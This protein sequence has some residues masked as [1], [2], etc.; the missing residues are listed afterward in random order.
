MVLR[1]S[2]RAGAIR[3]P[4]A[5]GQEP[6]VVSLRCL[7]PEPGASFDWHHHPFEE[8]TF[9]AGHEALIGYAGKKHL[10]KPN[11]LCMYRR[12]ER[13][14]GWCP[15]DSGF[16]SW[17]L[18]FNASQ[19][20]YAT[21]EHLTQPDPHGRIWQLSPDQA[22]TFRRLF[23]QILNERTKDENHGSAVESAW[24][25]LL[26]T[27]VDRWAK[28]DTFGSLPSEEVHPDIMRL[29][30]LVN[31]CVATPQEARRQIAALPNYDSLRHAFHKAFGCSPGQMMQRLRL[32]QAK[33]LL[34][35]TSLSIK[36]IALR[37][38]Y[39]RQHEFTRSFHKQTGVAPS[40]WRAN[41]IQSTVIL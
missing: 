14:G 8:L 26:L 32:Q 13:H 3:G 2:N 4:K 12:G 28:G 9:V 22:N 29:W 27:M 39:A 30:H 41:P 23:L 40:V 33:N 35:E 1:E 24:L 10:L 5:V 19:D 37:A 18:H 7:A 34:L 25:R 16:Q 36:E 11:T 17:V 21:V 6:C 38:G 15:R 31:S 20:F